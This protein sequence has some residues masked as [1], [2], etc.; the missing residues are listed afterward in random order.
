[1][2]DPIVA[3][4]ETVV[5]TSALKCFGET[6]N[7]KNKLT[8]IAEARVNTLPPPFPSLPLS[9]KRRMS[10]PADPP[11]FPSL[12]HNTK[13]Y[14]SSFDSRWTGAWRR[15]SSGAKCAPTG[16]RRSSAT[17][18]R[19][20]TFCLFF[21]FSVAPPPFLRLAQEEEAGRLFP[22]DRHFSSSFVFFVLFSCFSI[23]HS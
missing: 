22:G 11:F 18:S 1:M 15:T 2:A 14:F 5:E 3:F 8:M 13:K 21:F 6:P 12:Y 19:R 4:C 17:F 10:T 23:I 16:P 7:K 20:A 9:L